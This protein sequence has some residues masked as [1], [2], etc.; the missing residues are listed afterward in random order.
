ME[1]WLLDQRNWLP[2]TVM[3]VLLLRN[4]KSYR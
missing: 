1:P 3:V 4:R 2:R